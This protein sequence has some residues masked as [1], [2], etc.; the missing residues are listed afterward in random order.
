MSNGGQQ[1]P[2]APQAPPPP[3]LKMTQTIDPA[4][5]SRKGLGLRRTSQG[6]SG[7]RIDL[8]GVAASGNAGSGVNV[9]N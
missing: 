6:R 8:A 4:I 9:A 2:L 7:L 3:P 1:T 5:P